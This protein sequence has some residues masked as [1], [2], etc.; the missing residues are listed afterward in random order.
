L[1]T[2]V[3]IGIDSA[4]A[5]HEIHAECDGIAPEVRLHISNDLS[6][7]QRLLDVLREAF[8]DVPWRFALENPS[9]LIAKY[10]LQGGHSVSAVN[11]RSVASM[12]EALA[13]SGK[14]DDPLVAE[15]LCL[16]LRRRAEELA[17]VRLGSSASV[18]LAGLVR[19][20]VEIVEEKTRTLNQ[21]TVVLKGYY[22]RALELF[23]NLEQ[24]LTLAFL[25]AFSSPTALAAATEADW[26]A[27]FTGQRYPQ[28][29]RI[30]TLWEHAR[31]PQVPVSPAD[32]ALGSR[33]VQR[34]VRLL[35][36]LLEELCSVEKEI[37]TRFDELPDAQVFRS[38]PGAAEVLAPSLFGAAQQ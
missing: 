36:I 21:L 9:L 20:R 13:S 4:D 35:E 24:P 17:P 23:G 3:A 14:K 19:Q 32:E 34:L 5:S 7:F 25:R 38:L 33:Q 37:Q 6:G 18:I 16:L 26:K 1:P 29:G 12:R 2:F 27:L 15:A 30:L 31:Q 10:L 28:P 11:P 8:G 22:P